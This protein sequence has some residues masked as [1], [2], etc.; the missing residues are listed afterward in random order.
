VCDD[1]RGPGRH[2]FDLYYHFAPHL[3]LER[4]YGQDPAALDLLVQGKAMAA[5]LSILASHPLHDEMVCGRTDPI[6]GWVSTRYGSRMPAP[7]LRVGMRE[8]APA[9]AITVVAPLATDSAGPAVIR[10]CAVSGRAVAVEIRQED[11]ADLLVLALGGGEIRAERCQFQGDF[12]WLRSDQE[13]PRELLAARGAHCV[14]DGRVLLEHGASALLT[15]RCFRGAEP[16][17]QDWEET[18]TCAE[19]AE[20]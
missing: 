18:R 20:R 10:R 4:E 9:A 2:C 3:A 16:I 11:H 5:S 6:Q 1:F 7:V 14:V 19:S 17:Y 13:G 8:E 12:L 15:T